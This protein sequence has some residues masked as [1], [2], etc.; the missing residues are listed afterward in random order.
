MIAIQNAKLDSYNELQALYDQHQ[1]RFTVIP[2]FKN[3][4]QE[5]TNRRNTIQTQM[6]VSENDTTSTT[7]AKDNVQEELCVATAKAAAPVSAYADS[8]RDAELHALMNVSVPKLMKEKQGLLEAACLKIYNKAVEL[9]EQAAPFNLTGDLLS[10]VETLLEKWRVKLPSTGIQQAVITTSIENIAKLMVEIDAILKKQLDKMMVT[11]TKTDPELVSLWENARTIKKP[12]RTVTQ[13]VVKV[14]AKEDSKPVADRLVLAVNGIET[15][16]RTNAEGEAIF[17]PIKNGIY[18]VKVM[19]E[20][21]EPM[22]LKSCRIWM[23]KINR[24]EMVV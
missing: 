21:S 3:A 6:L 8:I 18:D 12:Q 23:G 13:L 14:Q 19:V 24:V 5:V 4:F 7:G 11:L 1:S 22:V 9:K 10:D 15:P 2:A 17:K 20:G 16:A